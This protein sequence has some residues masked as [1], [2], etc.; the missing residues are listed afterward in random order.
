MGKWLN[1][2]GKRG[3]AIDEFLFSV[4]CHWGCGTAVKYIGALNVVGRGIEHFTPTPTPVTG[5]TYT[6]RMNGITSSTP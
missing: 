5:A 1:G 4:P 2:V 6:P 3:E